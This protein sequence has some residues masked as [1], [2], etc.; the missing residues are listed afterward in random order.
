MIERPD[1]PRPDMPAG[2]QEANNPAVASDSACRLPA[3]CHAIRAVQA[4]A[5]S[6]AARPPHSAQRTMGDAY[7]RPHEAAPVANR[8]LR[9]TGTAAVGAPCRIDIRIIVIAPRP[10]TPT[11]KG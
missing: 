4:T 3:P 10:H 6:T 7:P 2:T 8:A 11:E 9:T 5:T 1:T